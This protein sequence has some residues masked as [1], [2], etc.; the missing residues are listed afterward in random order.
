MYYTLTV[1]DPMSGT[2]ERH[3]IQSLGEGRFVSF[4]DREDNDGPER[5]AY[6]EWVAEGNTPE[7]WQPEGGV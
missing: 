1:T 2:T 3:I 5:A 4:P 6:L 7:P